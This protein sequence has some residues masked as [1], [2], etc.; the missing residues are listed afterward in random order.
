MNTAGGSPVGADDTYHY[1]YTTL[2]VFWPRIEHQ[3]LIARWPT[4]P[5][6]SERHGTSTG[7]G[8]SDIAHSSRAPAMRCNKREAMSLDLRHTCGTSTST[9]Q[10]RKTWTVTRTCAPNP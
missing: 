10:G 8:S 5:P 9:T 3:K 2:A 7:N 4:W 1:S 6:R